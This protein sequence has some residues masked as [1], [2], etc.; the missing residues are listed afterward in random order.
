MLSMVS[1]QCLIIHESI[2]PLGISGTQGSGMEKAAVKNL[3]SIL[4][5]PQNVVVFC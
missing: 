4:L 2:N 1:F 5:L 3:L